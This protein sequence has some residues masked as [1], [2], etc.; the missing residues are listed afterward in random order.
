MKQIIRKLPIFTRNN[1]S[2]QKK[3]LSE[4][5]KIPLLNETTMDSFLVILAIENLIGS[6]MWKEKER[7]F[8][9]TT[10]MKK[11]LTWIIACSCSFLVNSKLD[12]LTSISEEGKDNRFSATMK[13]GLYPTYKISALICL[14]LIGVTLNQC[15]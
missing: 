9:V 13:L 14:S 15:Q 2:W 6:I 8:S 10:K 11:H 7:S 5:K 1:P 3:T 12:G 4:R